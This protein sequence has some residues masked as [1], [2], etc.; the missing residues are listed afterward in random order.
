MWSD[1]KMTTWAWLDTRYGYG[2]EKDT[3]APADFTLPFTVAPGYS[4]QRL[5]L[6]VTM[7]GNLYRLQDN[8]VPV[9]ATGFLSTVVTLGGTTGAR[10]VRYRTRAPVIYRLGWTV[11]AGAG[12]GAY[13]THATQDAAKVDMDVRRRS[14]VDNGTALQVQIEHSFVWSPADPQIPSTYPSVVVSGDLQ[15]LQSKA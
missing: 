11:S 15:W 10:E 1:L 2:I 5:I 8:A 14:P 7:T 3:A 9:P 4:I 6:S 13:W 12:G